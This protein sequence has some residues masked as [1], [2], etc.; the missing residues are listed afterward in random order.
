[1]AR[2]HPRR[3]TAPQGDDALCLAALSPDAVPVL[4]ALR[5]R[6]APAP[7]ALGGQA[8]R[9][10]LAAPPE[11]GED[12]WRVGLRIGEAR[13]QLWL[14]PVALSLLT[15][16]LGGAW[17]LVPGQPAIDA[18]WL[19]YA[20]LEW[21]EPLE[22]TLGQTIRLAPDDAR[23]RGDLIALGC[24]L[25]AAQR[26]GHATLWLSPAAAADLVPWLDALWPPA[27]RSATAVAW[28]VQWIAG[29]QDVSLAALRRLHPGDVVMLDRAGDTSTVVLGG[30]LAATATAHR[31][32]VRL[33]TPFHGL[34]QGDINMPS[35]EN[36]DDITAAAEAPRDDA[37]WER[38]P[39]RLVCELGRLE[40]SLGELKTLDP[41]SVLPLS[42]TA[43]D[44]VDLVVN[45]RILGK[46]KLVAIGDGLGV[47]V[48]RLSI[49]E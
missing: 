32:G 25:E 4:N 26:H 16:S 19:E 33:L 23:P 1:M 44:A 41:G 7:L 22:T 2:A 11:D 36:G 47:Q 28:P 46:G 27:P 31:E 34:S 13:A 8:L 17:P 49:D 18:L 42:R 40:L 5:R 48:L 24:R 10:C 12:A 21:L 38:L 3:P 30:R 15:A 35:T 37:Q 43:D 29:T 20:L 45:G 39:V 9:C 14:D 6:R